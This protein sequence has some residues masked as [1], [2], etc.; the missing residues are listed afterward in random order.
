ME[1]RLTT[2]L[3]DVDRHLGRHADRLDAI[4]GKLDAILDLLQSQ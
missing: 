3:D 4:D 2:R 1:Q